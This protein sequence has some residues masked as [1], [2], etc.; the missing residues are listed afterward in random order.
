[1]SWTL[2][3]EAGVDVEGDYHLWQMLKYAE[4]V[5]GPVGVW[6][7]KARFNAGKDEVDPND[8]VEI[9]NYPDIVGVLSAPDAHQ[10]ML[11]KHWAEDPRQLKLPGMESKAR[12]LAAS[13]LDAEDPKAVFKQAVTTVK[14]LA[15]ARM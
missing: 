3:K 15:P 7:V 10:K 4:H 1:M 8:V 14:R 12:A 5:L 2:L 13:L 9:E 11:H 6:S